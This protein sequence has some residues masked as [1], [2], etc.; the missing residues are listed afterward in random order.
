M[1]NQEAEI[2]RLKK[3]LKT[4]NFFLAKKFEDIRK[5][6]SEKTELATSLLEEL[7]NR[8]V[9]SDSYSFKRVNEIKA[10]LQKV[11]LP[12]IE[13]G[14]PTPEQPIG[15]IESYKPKKSRQSNDSSPLL[16]GW[17]VGFAVLFQVG[18]DVFGNRTSGYIWWMQ[19]FLLVFFG[20]GYALAI[21]QEVK[22]SK[23]LN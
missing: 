5:I 10:L 16:F 19:L 14:L 6:E 17:I 22:K 8:I 15:L 12:S 18:S 2:L 23:W 7:E 11:S 3:S 9:Q 13:E 1:N 4:A 20:S 21:I